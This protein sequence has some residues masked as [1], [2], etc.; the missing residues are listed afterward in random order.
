MNAV[1]NPRHSKR[2]ARA[3]II[4]QHQVTITA[5]SISGSSW[6]AL[7]TTCIGA[8]GTAPPLLNGTMGALSAHVSIAVRFITSAA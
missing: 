4:L 3:E 1:A 6:G 2:P 8:G 5:G 7:I